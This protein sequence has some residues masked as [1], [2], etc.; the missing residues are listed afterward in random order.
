M[1]QVHISDDKQPLYDIDN[2]G[3]LPP[4]PISDSNAVINIPL[5]SIG[6]NPDS[7]GFEPLYR[8]FSSADLTFRIDPNR[9]VE[10]EWVTVESICTKLVWHS[11][12]DGR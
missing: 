3:P 10:E 7:L 8:Y 6:F 2:H 9:T 5:T 12:V 4:I 11:C 1:A